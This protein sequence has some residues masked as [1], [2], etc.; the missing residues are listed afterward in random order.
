MIYIGYKICKHC[1][2][3][4]DFGTK[5]CCPNCGCTEYEEDE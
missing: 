1:N 4:C 5:H 3:Y 2:R